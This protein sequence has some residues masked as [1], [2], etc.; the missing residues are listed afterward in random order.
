MGVLCDVFIADEERALKYCFRGKCKCKNWVSCKCWDEYESTTYHHIDSHGVYDRDFAHL[1]S[2]LRGK[3]R[4]ISLMK[5]FKMIKQFSKQGP[6]I[7]TVPEDLPNLLAEQGKDELKCIA[8][9]WSDRYT[10][11]SAHPDE[12]SILSYLKLLQKL[13]KKSIR[14]NQKMYLWT[15]L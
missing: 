4:G 9:E 1:L 15:S 13:C 5:E 11:V 6:W 7:Q 14:L 10:E 3:K 12:K 8:K 2:I